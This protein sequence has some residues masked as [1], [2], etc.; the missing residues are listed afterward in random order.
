MPLEIQIHNDES[1]QPRIV[2]ISSSYVVAKKTAAK[3]D[4]NA[5][6]EIQQTILNILHSTPIISIGEWE[7]TKRT[8]G[9]D[10]TIAVL[11]SINIE[12]PMS[13]PDLVDRVEKLKLRDPHL[14]GLYQDILSLPI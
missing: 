10:E 11:R 7:R 9:E 8:R 1:N 13:L 14:I 2:S 12:T 5:H 6:K 4:F 3:Q